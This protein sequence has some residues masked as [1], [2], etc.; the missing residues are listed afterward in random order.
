MKRQ[1]DLSGSNGCAIAAADRERDDSFSASCEAPAKVDAARVAGSTGK[2]LMR[3]MRFVF[4]L[5]AAMSCLAL[6]A[7]CGSNASIR[8][9]RRNPSGIP[10]SVGPRCAAAPGCIIPLRDRSRYLNVTAAGA[11]PAL[12]YVLGATFRL[13]AGG[14]AY[15]LVGYHLGAACDSLL[16]SPNGRYVIYGTSRNGWPALM[17][18][19]LVTGARS[20]FHTRACAPAWER[21]TRSRTS[22]M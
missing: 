12:P 5:A 19:D 6:I 14:R 7:A 13:R 18:L 3:R 21:M 11:G 20:V 22:T 1:G 10:V 17:L 8:R 2:P 15:Q 9:L 16:L 4:R